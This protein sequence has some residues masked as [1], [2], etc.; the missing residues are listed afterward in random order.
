[1]SLT[2]LILDIAAP[3]PDLL[4]FERYLFIG[5]H[6]DDIE[7]GAGATAAK[8]AALGKKVAFVICT[9]GRYGTDNCPG[10]GEDEL[11]SLRKEEALRSAKLLGIEDVRF[12]GLSDGGFYS[13]DELTQRLFEAVESFAP[14]LIFAPDWC[15]ENEC[16]IDHLTVGKV[17]A[18]VAC[19]ASNPGI[20]RRRGL[21]AVP[22]KAIAYYMTAKPNSFVRTGEFEK[23]R[24]AAVFTCHLSQYPEGS[25][26][27]KA[28]RLYLS[29]RAFD[30][31]IRKLSCKAEGFRMLD[32][33]RMHCVSEAGL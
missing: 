9:D 11:A 24:Q 28:L 14:D 4:S 15:A 6:P 1:M 22:V 2:K 21:K 17:A 26:D 16:H 13:E 33:T 3:L 18:V 20:M 27:S 31:G 10:I 29:L 25:P 32:K 23:L 19:S 5:P 30:F 8:L 12:L 7:I